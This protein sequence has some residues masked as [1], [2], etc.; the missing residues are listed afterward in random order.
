VMADGAEADRG[1][2]QELV[3]HMKGPT[4]GTAILNKSGKKLKKC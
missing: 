3:L 2:P 1:G 4:S